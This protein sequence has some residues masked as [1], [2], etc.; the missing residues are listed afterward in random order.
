MHTVDSIVAASQCFIGSLGQ[1]SVSEI[2]LLDINLK[3]TQAIQQELF[4]FLR[5]IVKQFKT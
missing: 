4:M 5:I 3:K 1:L 2:N